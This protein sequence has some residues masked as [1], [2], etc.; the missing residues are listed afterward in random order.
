MKETHLPPILFES[1]MSSFSESGGG[2]GDASAAA[3]SSKSGGEAHAAADLQSGAARANRQ[4][5]PSKK[6]PEFQAVIMGGTGSSMATLTNGYTKPLLPILNRPMLS[7]QLSLLHKSKFSEAILVIDGFDGNQRLTN[8][9]RE[10]IKEYNAKHKLQVH[11]EVMT[12]ALGTAEVLRKIAHL[13]ATNFI[14]LPCDLVCECPMSAIADVFR[15]T[16]SSCTMLLVEPSKAPLSVRGAAPVRRHMKKKQQIF[17]M[18][19][20]SASGGPGKSHGFRVHTRALIGRSIDRRL[21]FSCSSFLVLLFCSFFGSVFFGLSLTLLLRL[22]FRR[23]VGR[24]QYY[25]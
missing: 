14:V 16:D 20:I 15:A 6:R 11:V 9:I 8:T 21:F 7:Y 5:L 17:G 10:F 12:E 22:C 13:I 19:P 4:A 1:I 3:K 24:V 23:C 25:S 2:G 18:T